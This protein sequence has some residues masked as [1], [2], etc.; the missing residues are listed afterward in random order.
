M[1]SWVTFDFKPNHPLPPSF[2]S[3]SK[4]HACKA[5]ECLYN[6]YSMYLSPAAFVLLLY[7]LLC[8][9]ICV[10]GCDCVCVWTCTLLPESWGIPQYIKTDRAKHMVMVTGVP[11]KYKGTEPSGQGET[12]RPRNPILTFCCSHTY[13]HTQTHIHAPFSAWGS[14]HPNRT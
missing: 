11:E 3:F 4:Y 6:N 9:Y 10:C 5:T 14:Q 1:T 7:R 8:V 2:Y 13:V 12:G